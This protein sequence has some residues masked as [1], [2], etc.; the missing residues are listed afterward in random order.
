MDHVMNSFFQVTFEQS[1][2]MEDPLKTTFE[3]N[4]VLTLFFAVYIRTETFKDS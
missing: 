1:R 4:C 2:I 3:G